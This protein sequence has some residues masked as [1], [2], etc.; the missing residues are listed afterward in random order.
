MQVFRSAGLAELIPM[1]YCPFETVVKYAV[2]TLR[3]LPM[4][5]DTV[6]AQARLLE[7]PVL[8]KLLT[9]IRAPV[10]NAAFGVIRNSALL[11]ANLVELT[12]Q[13]RDETIVSLIKLD[14]FLSEPEKYD[15]QLKQRNT[16]E[17]NYYDDHKKLDTFVVDASSTDDSVQHIT[18]V[19][20][21]AE[22]ELLQILENANNGSVVLG[23]MGHAHMDKEKITQLEV[24]DKGKTRK[25]ERTTRQDL[26]KNGKIQQLSDPPGSFGAPIFYPTMVNNR[27]Q[28]YPKRIIANGKSKSAVIQKEAT[29]TPKTTVSFFTIP[30]SL[31]YTFPTIPPP[32]QLFLFEDLNSVPYSKMAESMSHQ[33][34]PTPVGPASYYQQLQR[35]RGP[36]FSPVQALQSPK[37]HSQSP[38]E[39]LH[40]I[41]SNGA[42]GSDKT[43][44]RIPHLF[45]SL[46]SPFATDTREKTRQPT[47]LPLYYPFGL[48]QQREKQTGPTSLLGRQFF[49]PIANTFGVQVIF[50]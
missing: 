49:G 47:F 27:R 41:S 8:L 13:E 22:M 6:K 38:L 21:G 15:G 45:S 2:T 42:E 39:S 33:S 3:N 20:N 40:D 32:P 24:N 11:R 14:D 23:H 36:Q 16:V 31:T 19:D 46:R 44:R 28:R 50:P 10:I 1:L 34:N 12:Q 35:F 30:A 17:V 4:H 29:T 5:V 9:T 48:V 26:R 18:K 43:T 7:V 25:Y 37:P